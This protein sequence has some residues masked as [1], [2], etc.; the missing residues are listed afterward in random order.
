MVGD[1]CRV[2]GCDT[3]SAALLPAAARTLSDNRFRQLSRDPAAPVWAGLGS[4]LATGLLRGK[5]V[6][7]NYLVNILCC[8]QQQ[9]RPA[10]AHTT[11]AT[12]RCYTTAVAA[13][14]TSVCVFTAFCSL[15]ATHSDHLTLQH[16]GDHVKGCADLTL[17]HTGD[18]VM[19]VMGC[20][21]LTC[22]HL[23]IVMLSC[24]RQ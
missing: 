10:A 13:A 22:K 17:Q 12:A 21:D 5:Q 3:A 11:S 24:P 15:L 2:D 23:Q 18:H 20:P 9:L 6:Q 1:K 14:V 16:S 7:I 4:G 19:I 8:E